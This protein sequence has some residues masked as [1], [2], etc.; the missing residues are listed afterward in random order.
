MN[1]RF[2]S[3]IRYGFGWTAGAALFGAVFAALI[4]LWYETGRLPVILRWLTWAVLITA[5][6]AVGL[7]VLGD[8]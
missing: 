7:L 6:I 8:V 2:G 1:R 5:V 4:G 3:A